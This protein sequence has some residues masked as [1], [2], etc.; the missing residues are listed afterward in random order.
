LRD[1]G[2]ALVSG[3]MAPQSHPEHSQRVKFGAAMTLCHGREKG[4]E[5]DIC[6]LEHLPSRGVSQLASALVPRRTGQALLTKS[7]HLHVDQCPL[8][9]GSVELLHAGR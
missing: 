5:I 7:S 6:A 8:A 3:G 1:A 4:I 2:G 9:Y